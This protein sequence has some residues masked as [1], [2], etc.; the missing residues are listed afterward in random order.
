MDKKVIGV[1]IILTIIILV[2]EL[3]VVASSSEVIVVD[4]NGIIDAGTYELIKRGVNEAIKAH[5][6]ALILKLNT[7]G[8]YMNSMDD[9]IELLLNIERTMTTVAWVPPGGK[10]ASAGAFIALA[11][12]KLF[13]GSSSVIGACEPKP[14]DEKVIHYALGRIRS[15]AERKWGFNDTRVNLVQEFI[16]KNRALS[17]EEAIRLGIADGRAES[18]IDVINNLNL[19]GV[20]IR[21]ISK[22][23]Y[24]EF[25]SLIS[26]PS[27]AIFLIIAGLVLIGFEV[28][29][30]G[31]QGWG[32]VGTIMAIVGLYGLGLVGTSLLILSLTAAGIAFLIAELAQPGIQVFGATGLILLLIAMALA[33]RNEPYVSA[34]HMMALA[35]TLLVLTF[36]LL[37]FLSIKIRKALKRKPKSIENLVGKIGLAKTDIG[38][39]EKGVAYIEGE[40]WSAVSIKGKIKAGSKVRVLKVEGLVLVVEPVVKES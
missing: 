38:E 2:E 6:V 26:D 3:I 34:T 7:Y 31:F 19:K 15:L 18:I 9:I 1:L 14:P 33:Y 4:V 40:D 25:L 37:V 5:A 23:L 30:T 12:D 11:C 28:T 32:I 20:E 36:G 13:M 35:V 21:E 24:E 17:D 29:V 39:V 27:I 10:A 22:G 8:G 16:T